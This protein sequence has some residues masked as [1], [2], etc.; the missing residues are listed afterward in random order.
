MLKSEYKFYYVGGHVR[1]EFLGRK[2][3]DIDLVCVGPG[4]FGELE[5]EIRRLKGEIYISK[6]EY[7]TVRCNIPEIGPCDIR[8]ARMDGD[9][10]DGR[11]PD[12]VVLANSIIEDL[13]CRDFCC[14][15]IAKDVETGEIIDPFYGQKD[16]EVKVIR[17]VG[18][19]AERF[20]EDRLRVIRAI[21]QSVTLNFYL[22]YTIVE[23]LRGVEEDFLLGV[24][25][26][27][28]YDELTKMFTFDTVKS[29]D[30]IS[31]Y[32]GLKKAIFKN[33]WLKPSLESR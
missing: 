3:K 12:K 2:S 22:S 10:S 8:L 9:Y 13:S 14:N 16:I 23:Y 17:C 31:E 33:V 21:R 15:A 6:P 18:N 24:S 1:D 28:I 32:K 25:K 11:H 5:K 20:K 19:P 27:R 29:I 7:L 30:I 26:E 4:S